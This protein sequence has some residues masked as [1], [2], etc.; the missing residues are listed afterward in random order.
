MRLSQHF[1]FLKHYVFSNL[2]KLSFYVSLGFV[3]ILFFIFYTNTLHEEYPDEFDNILGGFYIL[4]G[5]FPFSGFFSHHGPVAYFV[6]AIIALFSNGSFV[7]FRIVY[8][9][10][11]A[12]FFLW[13]YWYLRVRVSA[14]QSRFYLISVLIFGLSA[15]YFW[16]H[17]LLADS[18]ASVLIMPVVAILLL[19]SMQGKQFIRSDLVIISALTFLMIFTSLT[20]VYVGIVV[21]VY[22]L[23]YYFF[24]KRRGML[25]KESLFLIAIFAVPYL[26]F[27]I[28]LILTGSF[29]EYFYQSILYNQKYYIYNYPKPEGSTFINPD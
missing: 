18:L 17:M 5:I 20:H 7:T 11:L 1:T 19:R 21:Y 8:S 6:A 9:I 10:A 29:D 3:A 2:R 28:Y 23:Y 12:L 16:L 27:G 13:S 25:G 24:H 26:L 15:T 4:K 14:T 22:T